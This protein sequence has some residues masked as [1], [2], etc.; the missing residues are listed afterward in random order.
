MTL[1]REEKQNMMD[2]SKYH[3]GYYP[4]DKTYNKWG[5]RIIS[6]IRPYGVALTCATETRAW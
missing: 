1:Y 6:R 2:A 3:I 4:V 5:R